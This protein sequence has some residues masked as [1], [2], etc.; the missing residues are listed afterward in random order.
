[1]PINLSGYMVATAEDITE[2][3]NKIT[4]VRNFTNEINKTFQQRYE[5]QAAQL[6]NLDSQIAEQKTR[7]EKLDAELK[8]LD[9]ALITA[10]Q[11]FDQTFLEIE[12]EVK[13][14]TGYLGEIDQSL[15]RSNDFMGKVLETTQDQI[16]EGKEKRDQ[17]NERYKDV[18]TQLKV[19]Q[20]SLHQT[21]SLIQE[22]LKSILKAEEDGARQ[23]ERSIRM[24]HDAVIQ[25][26]SQTQDDLF[27]NSQAIQDFSQQKQENSGIV[28][29][30]YKALEELQE[31]IQDQLDAIL[32]ISKDVAASSSQAENH[33][34]VM[35]SQGNEEQSTRLNR[36][37][38]ELIRRGD[39]ISALPL[40]EKAS[41]LTPQNENIKINLSLVYRKSGKFEQ[42]QSLLVDLIGHTPD[43]VS[44]L[45]ELGALLLETKQPEKA[46][47]YLEHAI[48]V[49]TNDPSLW[50]N[51]GKAYFE[52][53]KLPQA[54]EAWEQVQKLEPNLLNQDVIARLMV[55][56]RIVEE[57][58]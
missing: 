56:D 53:N 40:L 1:M 19:E 52:I 27:R 18:L 31:K 10:V 39:S 12:E 55:M 35:L 22:D 15:A 16:K 20:D 45:N 9:Q 7:A 25:A 28:Q 21:F 34:R 5:D 43:Q 44:A 6:K 3:E 2:I 57:K 33:E 46:I 36:Q 58:K 32:L 49:D 26:Q 50:M 14:S 37:A 48:S 24:L 4:R 23:I 41:Q 38:M 30:H 11:D 54:V 13:Q 8:R 17:V 47:T 29:G 42:A 51:L